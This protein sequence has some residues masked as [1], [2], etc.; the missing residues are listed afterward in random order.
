MNCSIH[1]FP[2][3]R[4]RKSLYGRLQRFTTCD[5]DHGI[6]PVCGPKQKWH[7]KHSVQ[8]ELLHFTCRLLW[9]RI[10]TRSP[11]TSHPRDFYGG[12]RCY[13]V[14]FSPA[15]PRGHKYVGSTV[16]TV[17]SWL[18]I[19]NLQPTSVVDSRRSHRRITARI[20]NNITIATNTKSDPLTTNGW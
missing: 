2:H 6:K 1:R 11:R 20:T 12:H 5:L 13:P 15:M 7:L 3:R 10:T 16:E 4:G 8:A 14:G 18:R 19:F 17:W 9:C